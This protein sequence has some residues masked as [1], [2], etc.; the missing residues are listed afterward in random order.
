MAN[1]RYI[2]G[3]DG[4]PT[5]KLVG[6]T[7]KE[8]RFINGVLADGELFWYQIT[9]NLSG[10]TIKACYGSGDA[11]TTKY[12][13]GL[14]CVEDS[15]KTIHIRIGDINLTTN[16][17]SQWGTLDYQTHWY[18]ACKNVKL[19][20]VGICSNMAMWI[21]PSPPSQNEWC[22]VVSAHIPYMQF[23]IAMHLDENKHVTQICSF[24]H[25]PD[26]YVEENMKRVDS[27]EGQPSMH[28]DPFLLTHLSQD[29]PHTLK[30]ISSIKSDK[31]QEQETTSNFVEGI[32][33]NIDIQD[34]ES[35]LQVKQENHDE[36]NADEEDDAYEDEAEKEAED[37]PNT[38]SVLVVT[39]IRIRNNCVFG[40]A[41]E[42]WPH[43]CTIQDWTGYQFNGKTF[44][45]LYQ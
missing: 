30:L 3:R 22:M 44:V 8:V 31:S 12:D 36:E 6:P 15:P 4:C 16:P 29:S 45:N 11:I 39:L 32:P 23:S 24:P 40:V 35:A 10:V 28:H 38:Q 14:L 34:K 33:T 27:Y 20:R 43:S 1:A 41:D 21:F 9:C 13:P 17:L 25:I 7:T 18:I 2:Y 5:I 19:T 26:Q 42:P 37:D